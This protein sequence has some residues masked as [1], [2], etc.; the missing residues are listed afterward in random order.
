MADLP[1]ALALFDQFKKASQEEPLDA[2]KALSLLAQLKIAMTKF[3]SL[4]PS[5]V[6]S[7]TMQQELLFAREV[8]ELATMLSIRMQDLAAIERNVAQLK[9][10]Y[11]DYSALLQLT[12][13]Q[14]QFP[15]LGLNLL[16]LLA[17][18][19]IAEFHTELEL[20]SQDH[21]SNVYIKFPILIEQYLMEGSYNKIV[22][23][24]DDIPADSYR[25]LMDILLHTVRDEIADCTQKAYEFVPVADMMRTLLMFTS[26]S[27]FQT[28]VKQRG[29][30]LENGLVHF[31]SKADGRLEVP[32]LKLITQTLAYAK[33]LERIV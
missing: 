21:Y 2:S 20:I 10:Y 29:W 11:F 28:Y 23:A 18:N 14:R 16:R 1:T 8:L 5:S 7:P 12:P 15:I 30:R 25:F 13:S 31:Q 9:T 3:T 22:S 33:E 4:P 17:Q 26:D 24:R 6:Q 32:S 19:R 27:E